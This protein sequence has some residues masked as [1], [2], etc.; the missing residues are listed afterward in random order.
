MACTLAPPPAERPAEF[1]IGLLATLSG[2][3]AETA[4]KSTVEGA[5]LAIKNANDSGGVSVGGRRERVALIVEDDQDR[6]EAAID[7]ARKLISQE[8]I[9]VI[10]GPQFSRNAIPVAGVAENARVPMISPAS[11]RP[12]TTA[13]KRYVFRAAFTD[14]L[15][16]RVLAQFARD[17]LHAHGVGVLYDVA[18]AY[19]KGL[20]EIFRDAFQQAGGQVVAFESYTTDARTNLTSQL[21]RVR[22]SAP[23]VLFLPN[24]ADEVPA[25][26]EQARQ[27]GISSMLLGS[28]SWGDIAPADLQGL[29]GAFYTGHW[30]PNIGSAQAQ[31]F[32]ASYREAYGRTPTE[33]AALTYDA[34]GLLFQAVVNQGSLDPESVRNGLAS[35]E[36]YTGV[37]GTLRFQGTGDPVRSIV[38][39]QI[40]GGRATFYKLMNP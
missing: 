21:G 22:A 28:D 37:T 18:S 39:L 15:Q 34:L 9:A 14:P 38:M 2:A 30:A 31:A 33:T 7:A 8:G 40:R 23:Q 35:V 6:S 27:L 16:G 20:A 1:R 17:E 12:E 4:G 25:Q 36:T 3:A 10:I 19:N 11:T 13:G 24:Y 29:E 5:Q 32:I 26:V